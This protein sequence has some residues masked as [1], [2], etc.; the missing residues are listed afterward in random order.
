MNLLDKLVKSTTSSENIY[1]SNKVI[2]YVPFYEQIWIINV[3][4]PNESLKEENSNSK[5]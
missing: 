1:D 5:S 2:Y 3:H 4:A